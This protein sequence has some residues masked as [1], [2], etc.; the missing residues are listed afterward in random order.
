MGCCVTNN[1]PGRNPESNI[2][3]ERKFNLERKQ[4]ISHVSFRKRIDLYC[5]LCNRSFN[6]SSRSPYSLCTKSHVACSTCIN[7]FYKNKVKV[8]PFCDGDFKIQVN[9]EFHSLID[10][11][12]NVDK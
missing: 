8:C 12:E 4:S 1:Q 11:K 5:Q 3:Q 9:L 7:T 6:N 2:L 10:S